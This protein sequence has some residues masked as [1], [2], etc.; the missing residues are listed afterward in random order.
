MGNK[1][2]NLI[3]AI[4]TLV[5]A[6]QGN[7]KDEDT[8][9]KRMLSYTESLDLAGGG[10]VL[11]S[12]NLINKADAEATAQEEN[13]EF[14]KLMA[15]LILLNADSA[16][17]SALNTELKNAS[18]HGLNYYPTMTSRAYELLMR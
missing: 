2:V 16:K 11:I 4:K 10:H 12:P 13:A 15:V 6:R 3:K 5:N 14:E 1:H 7:D 8:Y 17:Y 18:H 9:V